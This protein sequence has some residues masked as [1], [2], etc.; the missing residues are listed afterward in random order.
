[1][2]DPVTVEDQL[3]YESRT[4]TGASIVAAAAGVLLVTAAVVQLTGLHAKVQELTVDL[5]TEHKRYP[6]DLIVAIINGFAL[7]G[8]AWTLSYLYGLAKARNEQLQDFMKWLALVGGGLSAVTAVAYAIAIAHKADQF[9]SHGNQ[10]YE[11]ANHLTST[12][13]VVALPLIAQLASLLLT[14]G[15]VMIA[16]NAMRVGL[17]TRF[18]GYLGIFAGVLVL[19]PIGSPVPVVQGFWL[20]SLA[21]LISGRWPSGVPAAWRSGRAEP[22]PSS[23]E[24]RARREAAA[25]TNGKPKPPPK[26]KQAEPEPEEDA[27][28]AAGPARTRST[29]PKRKRKR[30]H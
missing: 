28:A 24:L 26:P 30:R 13:Y 8:V 14:V 2:S 11:E 18:M 1:M 20:L 4:R 6:L 27:V 17:L 25:S 15:F 16:L 3:A 21:Y 22:W 29:T 7:S 9:V 10:T 5:I 23:A 19:L 12:G